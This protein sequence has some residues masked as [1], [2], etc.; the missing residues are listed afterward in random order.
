M[1]SVAFE[2]R[3]AVLKSKMVAGAT[4]NLYLPRDEQIHQ[5]GW[6]AKE[7]GLSLKSRAKYL[8]MCPSSIAGFLRAGS[9]QKLSKLPQNMASL[10][11]S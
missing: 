11:H 7:S 4:S 9:D 3:T 2:T 8:I 6:R 5:Q 10:T 1:S